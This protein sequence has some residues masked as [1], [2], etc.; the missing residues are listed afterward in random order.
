MNKNNFSYWFEKIKDIDEFKIPK[1]L[2]FKVPEEIQEYLYDPC[3]KEDKIND[4][5]KQNVVPEIEK[6][7]KTPFFFVKNATFSDKYSNSCMTYLTTLLHNFININ[8]G[9]LCVGA[10]GIDELIVR[11]YIMSDDRV[12][13]KIYNGLPLRNEIRIFYDFD[14]R[15]VLYSVNYWDYDY[16]KSSMSS[17]TDKIIF[18]YMKDNLA[19]FYQDFHEDIERKVSKAMEKVDLTG[20]WS[21][22]IL[23]DGYGNDWLI[24]M[25]EAERSAYWRG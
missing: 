11:E 23:T 1:S 22:D 18:E 7:I 15:K 8:Y 20:K 25:A 24:D 13:P 19:Y 17:L 10:G 16:C 14:E 4:W 21:I 3:G 5:L 2:I 12:T 6:N 9:A